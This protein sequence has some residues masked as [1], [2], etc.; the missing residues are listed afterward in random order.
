M[1]RLRC[2]YATVQWS[3]ALPARQI[4]TTSIST[5]VMKSKTTVIMNRLFCIAVAATMMAGCSKDITTDIHPGSQKDNEI[6]CYGGVAVEATV[7]DASRVAVGNNGVAS[8]TAWEAGDEI[9]IAYDGKAYTYVAQNAGRTSTFAPK[10]ADNAIKTIE[11]AQSVA[12]FYNVASV[13][14]A[15]K[16]ATF[17]IATEQVEG[18]LSNK[19]PLYGYNASA[20][21]ADGKIVLTMSPLASIVEFEVKASAD[22]HA[23]ALSLAPARNANSTGYTVVTGAKVDAATGA[24]DIASAT[25]GTKEIKVAFAS[26]KN[27]NGS[28]TVQI[29]VGA[30]SFG[31]AGTGEGGEYAGG[32]VVKLYKAGR[33]NFRR[34]IWTDEAKN[35][36]L[37]ATRKHIYQPLADIL[38]GHRNGISTAEDMKAF[39]DEVNGDIEQYP[40]GVGFCNED[41]VVMLNGDISLA[42]Y[43]AWT[44]IANFKGVFEG[45][46]HHIYGI[47]VSTSERYAGLFGVVR[48]E[49]RNV[50]LGSKDGTAYDGT[51]AVEMKYNADTSTWCYAG[52][53]AQV[54]GGELNNIKTFIPVTTTATSNCKSRIGGLCGSAYNASLIDCNNY[55]AVGNLA[56][57]GAIS[58][59]GG[60]SGVIDGSSDADGKI[61]VKNCHNHAAVT[62]TLAVANNAIGGIVGL[63][64]KTAL[65]ATIENCSNS[66]EVLFDNATAAVA[67]RV[68]GIVGDCENSC[69]TLVVR[70]CSNSGVVRSTMNGNCFIGGIFGVSQGGATIEECTNDGDVT[71]EQTNVAGS[72]Y[73]SIGGICGQNYR[74]TVISGCTNNGTVKSTKLQVSRIGG[75]VGTHNTSSLSDCEN[76]G[77]VILAIGAKADNWEAAGGIVGFYDGNDAT[78]STNGCSN[79]GNVTAT[80][81]TSNA[82]VGAGGIVGVIKLGI[83]D[84]NTNSGAVSIHNAQSGKTAYAGGVLGLVYSG[85]G[86][87]ADNVNTGSV[88]ASVEGT[89]ATLAAGGVVGCNQTGKVSGG[90][91]TGDVVCALYAGAAIGWNKKTAS[92]IAVGGSVNGTTLTAANFSSL[93]IGKDDGTSDGI[94]FKN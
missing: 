92:G 91:S 27:L 85:A 16:T 81:N 26:A 49:L 7:A 50:V 64:I 74:K 41:G 47:K 19:L 1:Y 66:G 55:G 73:V 89:S 33:E 10:D 61:S 63:V 79:S 4:S 25:H 21:Y 78:I 37:T 52:A 54:N 83:I 75:I 22:W 12:A 35:V 5:N 93:A 45:N 67:H 87:I 32:A 23:D 46:N 86:V 34:V 80:V 24:I 71:F 40:V 36:D 42:A 72:G 17:D 43:E 3:A 14:V 70:Q 2:T 18:E 62:G 82:S 58:Y 51:S 20:Q 94:L 29:V 88:K 11:A 44:P 6:N 30:A 90:N 38:K 13:D 77:D 9:T 28:K 15:T 56:A 84:G 60:V 39:A 65:N 8:L 59:V 69:P 53:V 57:K 76:T 31:S 68:G 48:G